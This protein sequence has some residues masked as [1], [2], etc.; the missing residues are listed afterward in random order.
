MKNP[1]A[2]VALAATAILLVGCSATTPGA[3]TEKPLAPV[4]TLDVELPAQIVDRGRLVIGVTCDSPPSGYLNLDGSNTGYEIAIA[5]QLA[6][7][8]F[9]DA[10][11]IEY[12][13]VDSSNRIPFLTSGKIDLILASMAYTAERAEQIEF[14]DPYWVSNLRLVVP[15][16]SDIE[17]YD[18]LDGKVVLTASGSTYAK[19]LE[20]CYPNT[21]LSLV[22]TIADASTSLKQGRGDAFAW[23]DVWNYNW[24]KNNGDFTVVADLASPSYQGIGVQK[25]DA[26]LLAWVNA[27]LAELRAAD[28]FYE[29][30]SGEVTDEEFVANY[31]DVVPGPDVELD[32]ASSNPMACV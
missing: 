12:Q 16:G 2:G 10:E 24:A 18:D 14:S 26:E 19:W 22:P 11:A 25:G 32:Y 17:N 5:E 31:R 20:Q 21:T 9:G 28:A 13:C 3:D 4:A 30:F 1:L 27:A 8:G 7:M 23:V 6:L 29:A 15:K